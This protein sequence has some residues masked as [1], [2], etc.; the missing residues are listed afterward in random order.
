VGAGQQKKHT[1]YKTDWLGV[2]ALKC[3]MDLWVYQEILFRSRPEVIVETGVKHGGSALYLASV[4]DLIGEG[5]IV[6]VDIT[7][8]NLAPSVRK[9]PRIELLEGSS[10]ATEIYQTIEARCKN[11]RTMVI[12]DSDHTAQHVQEELRLYAP[13]VTPGCYLICED[14]NINGH[15]VFP[16]F[17]PGPYEAVQEFL[18]ANRNWQVDKECEKL[19]VTFNPSGYLKRVE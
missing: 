16:S 7:L 5:R 11:R 14:T 10:T 13:L 3:P 4:C 1:F 12:L 2:P 8:T 15:P 9:H 18:S 17:G 19:L 6:S